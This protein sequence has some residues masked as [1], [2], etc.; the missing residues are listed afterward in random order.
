MRQVRFPPFGFEFS[1]F[2][3]RELLKNPF[4]AF[5]DFQENHFGDKG[6]ERCARLGFPP[7]GSNFRSS[8]SGS[9]FWSCVWR[10][11]ENIFKKSRLTKKL[12]MVGYE[13][14]IQEMV[15]PDGRSTR[16]N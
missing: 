8:G 16:I 3:L 7:L 11:G 14:L 9:L 6:S 13:E 15:D 1:E 2:G 10:F 4:L 12:Q 5:L